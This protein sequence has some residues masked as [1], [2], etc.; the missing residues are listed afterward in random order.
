MLLAGVVGQ[1][2]ELAFGAAGLRL[3]EL[4]RREA[5]RT[6]ALDQLPGPGTDGEHTV[7][8]VENE[9]FAGRQKGEGRRM[10]RRS[11]RALRLFRGGE[12]GGEEA[13]AVFG[14]AGGERGSGDVGER[15]EDVGEA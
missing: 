14:G 13:E 9:R 8:G 3:L 5:A 6:E 1:I 2:V 4:R 7:A 11:G 10:D 12:E 15:G